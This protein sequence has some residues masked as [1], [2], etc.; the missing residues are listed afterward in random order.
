MDAQI[1][2][3]SLAVDC[4]HLVQNKLTMVFWLSTIVELNLEVTAREHSN[5][6]LAPIVVQ[7]D[8][9]VEFGLDQDLT[10]KLHLK[11]NDLL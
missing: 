1:V 10:D 5:A 2:S 7:V 6:L 8:L 4:S 11:I 9:V 3:V